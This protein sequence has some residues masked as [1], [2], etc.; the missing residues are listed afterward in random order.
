MTDAITLPPVS[1]THLDA[2]MA[3]VA[4]VGWPHRRDDVSALIALGRGR[5]ARTGEGRTLGVGLWW[6]FGD[7]AARL[8]LLVVSPDSQGLGVGRR[9][10]ERLLA[11]AAPRS[12]MLLATSAGRPLYQRLGFVEV[13]G[14]CQHQGEYRGGRHSDPR[15]RV[16][17]PEDRHAVQRLDAAAFGVPRP[18]V[19]DHLMAAGRA[20][21]LIEN[22][23]VAGYA[24]ERAF[25]RGS[26]V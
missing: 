19:L 20:V 11:D 22:G 26:V 1:M 23:G 13:G 6:P 18:A 24:I 8:G 14:V 9:L 3:L 16:A 4:A 10:M 21:V 2:V 5:L 15:I 7:T 25:G 17:T 12:I